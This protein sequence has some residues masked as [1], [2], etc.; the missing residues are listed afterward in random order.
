MEPIV[1]I[2]FVWRSRHSCSGK[3]TASSGEN[4]TKVVGGVGFEKKNVHDGVTGMDICNSHHGQ[5]K[6]ITLSLVGKE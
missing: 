6:Q 2:T 1:L 3:G 4:E 5:K